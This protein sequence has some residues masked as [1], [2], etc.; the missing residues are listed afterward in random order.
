MPIK[1]H[2]E[3]IL[4]KKSAFKIGFDAT[5]SFRKV[6]GEEY[7]IGLNYIQAENKTRSPYL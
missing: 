2:D 5:Q 1:L 7:D 3:K 6:E 4:D